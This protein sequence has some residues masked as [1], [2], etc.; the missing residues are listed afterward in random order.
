MGNEGL[1]V[2]GGYGGW[3]FPNY[4]G[5]WGLLSR[6]LGYKRLCNNR[7]SL[8]FALW[9]YLGVMGLELMDFVIL[10]DLW[11]FPGLTDRVQGVSKLCKLI[12]S[13]INRKN[14]K[15]TI[16]VAQLGRRSRFHFKLFKCI[17][18]KKTGVIERFI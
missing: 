11:G 3:W 2:Y 5:Y 8:V 15:N 6:L 7:F 17:H 10:V 14:L 9:G 18:F 13:Y 12:L 1:S 4:W 16:L